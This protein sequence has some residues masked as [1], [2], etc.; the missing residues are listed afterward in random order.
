M[1]CMD[2]LVW[3][4]MDMN[5]LRVFGILRLN[6][7]ILHFWDGNRRKSALV[8][9]LCCFFTS[10]LL[11]LESMHGYLILGLACVCMSPVGV[12]GLVERE[13]E[14]IVG[15]GFFREQRGLGIGYIISWQ[16]RTYRR[17]ACFMNSR[18]SA[19]RLI[20]CIQDLQI[21]LLKHQFQ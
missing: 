13:G 12:F 20:K 8:S 3:D 5:S 14:N 11:G 2:E 15:W 9:V 10:I 21:T 18:Q 19:C 6:G 16:R 17:N 1:G 7:W 4:S